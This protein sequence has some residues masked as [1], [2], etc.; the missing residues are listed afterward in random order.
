VNAGRHGFRCTLRQEA[1]MEFCKRT[2]VVMGPGGACRRALQLSLNLEGYGVHAAESPGEARRLIDELWP[3]AVVVDVSEGNPDV[4]ALV[5]D[6]RQSR[7][8]RHMVIVASSPIGRAEQERKAFE[9]GCDAFVI[10]AGATR[11]LAELLEAYLPAS[12]GIAQEISAQRW[13]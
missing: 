5:R 6:I 8:H 9:A 1:K 10:Q 3:E 11:E 7:F 13:N 12:A 4:L 2:I